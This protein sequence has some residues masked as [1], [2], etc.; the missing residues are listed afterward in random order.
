MPSIQARLATGLLVSLILLLLLQWVVVERSIDHLSE[1]Y[2]LSRLSHNSDLLISAVDTKDGIL[3]VD[4]T[5]LD[6]VYSQPFSGFYYTITI[7]MQEFR[8]R[9]LWDE[10]LKG[11]DS[12]SL[13]A[14]QTRSLRTQGPQGQ[15]LLMLASAY[16]KKNLD[17]SVV[18]AEDISHLNHEIDL[19]LRSHALLSFLILTILIVIQVI[20]VRRGLH[21]LEKARQEL[22]N[23]EKGIIPELSEKV[24]KEI[25]PLVHEVNLRIAAFRQRLERSRRVSGN[26]AHALKRPLTLLSQQVQD[27]EALR[28]DNSAARMQGDIDEIRKIIDRELSRAKMAGSAMGVG[29]IDLASEAHSLIKMLQVMYERKGLQIEFDAQQVCKAAIDREDFHEVMGN[30]LDNACKW[31]KQRIIVTLDCQNGLQINLE[32][33][34]PGIPEDQRE[35]IMARGTRLDEQVDGHGLGMS[36][37]KDIVDQYQGSIYLAQ[38]STL[39]GLSVSVRLS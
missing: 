32:D 37:V 7:A 38:S 10:S 14:G 13:Q 1:E 5:R 6:P 36:I 15:Q 2:V 30:L 39:G 35:R 34:G 26:L 23:L 25:Y 3:S 24:P 12:L 19:L 31:A 20:I 18:V 16:R 17:V 27:C 29:Q 4:K 9:S 28:Q 33:D 21:P 8:S 11:L 22:I